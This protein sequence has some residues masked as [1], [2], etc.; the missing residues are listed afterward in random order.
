MYTSFLPPLKE[1][2]EETLGEEEGGHHIVHFNHV[3]L[4][5]G[6]QCDRRMNGGRGGDRWVIGK[7]DTIFILNRLT[8]LA[9]GYLRMVKTVQQ[10]KVVKEN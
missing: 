3:V 2:L 1:F 6:G 7:S 8:H 4:L 5:L 10:Q 9:N